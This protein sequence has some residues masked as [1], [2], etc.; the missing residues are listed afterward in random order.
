MK[1]ATHKTLE[2]YIQTGLDS[3]LRD[4]QNIGTTA[5]KSYLDKFK[6]KLKTKSIKSALRP[7]KATSKFR[8]FD[9][10]V[11]DKPSYGPTGATAMSSQLGDVGVSD[12]GWGVG[13]FGATAFGEAINRTAKKIYKYLK[14]LRNEGKEKAILDTIAQ[15]YKEVFHNVEMNSRAILMG[16]QPALID[17]MKFD[18]NEF[19]STTNNYAGEIVSVFIGPMQ[20]CEPVENIKQWYVDIGIDQDVIDS[21][22]F[23]EKSD[24]C[25]EESALDLPN[26]QI[27]EEYRDLLSETISSTNNP[28]LIGCADM[29]LMGSLMELLAEHNIKFQID[30]KYIFLI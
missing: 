1:P 7:V 24:M 18:I 2:Q 28:I 6:I 5:K 3:I 10:A 23:I 20:G 26:N 12:G 22:I 17:H 8:T 27:S 15:G 13:E 4:M 9:C 11:N 21:I 30:Q 14:R 29:F 19:V 25:N 16:I